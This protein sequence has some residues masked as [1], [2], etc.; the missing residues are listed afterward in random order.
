MSARRNNRSRNNEGPH[1]NALGDVPVPQGRIEM[2]APPEID[3]TSDQLGVLF[4]ERRRAMGLKID[5]VAEDIKVKP[6]YLRAIEREEFDR[7]PTP[8]YARLFIRAY[9]E[10][11]GF[12]TSEVYALIDVNAPELGFTA[13][14]KPGPPPPKEPVLSGPLPGTQATY[15]ESSKK[16]SKTAFIWWAVGLAIVVLVIIGIIIV[17][18]GN[19]SEPESSTHVQQPLDPVV[20]RPAVDEPEEAA[21][22]PAVPVQVTTFQLTLRFDRDTWASLTADDDLVE[23]RVFGADEE[24]TASAAESFR[25]SLGHTV[26]VTASVDGIPLRPFQEWAVRLEGHLITRDSVALWRDTSD[27]IVTL[28]EEETVSPPPGEDTSGVR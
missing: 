22:E 5:E 19:R 6:E 2:G 16:Q 12:N 4:T 26:G 25:V 17:K 14:V 24:L 27:A 3:I 7:M 20:S 9:A 1:P 15:P 18:W 8:Q 10:R 13:K 23:N 11:L 28:Q 21:S